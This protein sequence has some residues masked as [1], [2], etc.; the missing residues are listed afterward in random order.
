M[1]GLYGGCNKI[2]HPSLVIY[3]GSSKNVVGRCHNE[4]LH[5]SYY[6]IRP[7]FFQL[8]GVIFSSC[9][10]LVDFGINLTICTNN[11][12]NSLVIY[13]DNGLAVFKYLSGPESEKVKKTITKMFKGYVLNITIQFN[14]KIV[15]YLDITLN[16]NNSTYQPNSKPAIKYPTYIKNQ[17]TV[18]A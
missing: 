9:S 18:Q 17:T 5:L 11:A 14:I 15:I 4:R 10:L 1:S 7:V 6:S 16:L 13:R 2:F 8:P 3:N 12:I